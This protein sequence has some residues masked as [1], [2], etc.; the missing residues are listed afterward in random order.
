MVLFTESWGR[1]RICEQGNLSHLRHVTLEVF[2]RY[3]NRRV[4]QEMSQVWSLEEF[5]TGFTCFTVGNIWKEFKVKVTD[6][7][8]WEEHIGK[9]EKYEPNS[10]QFKLLV[11]F[12]DSLSVD[13]GSGDTGTQKEREKSILYTVWKIP[14]EH[15]FFF[16]FC[17]SC[18][19]K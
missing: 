4:Q 15:V 19:L 7:I 18:R 3:P 12:K 10:E 2:V 9:E 13:S 14:N 16:S 8:T 11:I 1:L 5:Q 17:S 6:N